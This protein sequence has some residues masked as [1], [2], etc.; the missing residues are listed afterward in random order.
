MVVKCVRNL[1]LVLI[2]AQLSL[3]AM[4]KYLL[5]VGIVCVVGEKESAYYRLSVEPLFE[6]VVAY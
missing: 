5:C 2:H 3:D 6:V 1:L 4:A